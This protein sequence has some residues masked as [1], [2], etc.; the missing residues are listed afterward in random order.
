[1]SIYIHCSA[2]CALSSRRAADAPGAAAQGQASRACAN[3]ALLPAVQQR[4]TSRQPADPLRPAHRR[5]VLPRLAGPLAQ[6]K[7]HDKL[8]HDQKSPTIPRM[9]TYHTR[10]AS[11]PGSGELYAAGS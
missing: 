5:A 4:A 1:M 9:R 6:T 8:T 10:P 11:Q 2:S 3:D 7:P